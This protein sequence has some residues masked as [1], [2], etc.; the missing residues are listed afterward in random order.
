MDAPQQEIF[1]STGHWL[2][3]SR[4]LMRTGHGIAGGRAN[5]AFGML[6]VALEHQDG[7]HALA[8]LGHHHS[9]LALLRPAIDAQIR[10]I[11]LYHCASEDQLRQFYDH[12]VAIPGYRD[13]T[14]EVSSTA[15]EYIRF[16]EFLAK[17]AP[18]NL[19]HDFTHGGREQLLSSIDQLTGD[20]QGTPENIPVLLRI[21]A[22][23]RY[24]TCLEMLRIVDARN[25]HGALQSAFERFISPS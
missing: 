19:K 15:P 13:L 24:F 1:R 17:S 9:A 6:N 4:R 25:I 16:W 2:D 14:A 12:G 22:E 5:M 11:W 10:G 23:L 8:A 20:L 3:A 18:H 21:I 7:I